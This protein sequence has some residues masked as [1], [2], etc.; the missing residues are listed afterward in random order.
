MRMTAAQADLRERKRRRSERLVSKTASLEEERAK[1]D[2][3]FGVSHLAASERGSI[4]W[5]GRKEVFATS[6]GGVEELE[7]QK[8]QDRK[9]KVKRVKVQAEDEG[10]EAEAREEDSKVE[11]KVEKEEEVFKKGKKPQRRKPKVA[12]EDEKLPER[13]EESRHLVGAHVSA[14][15]GVEKAVLNSLRVGGN[16]F[17]CFVRPKMQ[18]ESKPLTTENK[19]EFERLCKEHGYDPIRTRGGQGSNA[20]KRLVI[21][22]VVPHGCYLI[23]LGNPD[24]DKRR[25]SMG[26]FLDDLERCRDLG[27]GLYNFHPG[28]TVGSCERKESLRLVSECINEA[29]AKVKGVTILVENMAG[30]GNVIGSTFEELKEIIDQVVDKERV[31][32]CLDTCH[33]FA[34]GYDMRDRDSYE[35]TF[36][37]LDEIVGLKHLKAMHLN[38]S[39]FDLGSFK[40]RHE[41]IGWGKLGLFPFYAIMN[42]PRLIDIPLI[43]ETPGGD[44]STMNEVWTREIQVL[45]KL[46]TLPEDKKEWGEVLEMIASI[47]ALK[48]I[49]EGK[50]KSK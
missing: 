13:V 39:K 16:C 8:V 49:K 25:K 43:L 37:R 35:E 12:F 19:R 29:H 27:V 22:K 21:S 11:V 14:A 1:T 18:W 48:P 36:R 2:Q 42:D 28:S 44:D 7:G 38:D 30:A 46:E 26:A 23:N 41:N 9:P 4:G 10:R 50:S 33:A 5:R 32:I 34:A 20:E 17:S 31:G 40:D 24:G 45:Y 3:D 15:G 47:Q 6:S